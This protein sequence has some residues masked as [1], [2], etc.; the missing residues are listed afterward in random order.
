MDKLKKYTQKFKTCLNDLFNSVEQDISS[1]TTRKDPTTRGP[2]HRSPPKTRKASPKISSKTKTK[3][4]PE[5]LQ[6]FSDTDIK[7][8]S[9]YLYN[10]LDRSRKNVNKN[11]IQKL[12]KKLKDQA[13]FSK[14]IIAKPSEQKIED[15]TNVY[16]YHYLVY[17]SNASNKDNADAGNRTKSANR[18]KSGSGEFSNAGSGNRANSGEFSNAGSGN[19]ANSGSGN[20]ANSGE[21]SNPGSGNIANSGEFSNAGSGNMSKSG[22]GKFSDAGNA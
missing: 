10:E 1:P 15:L 2:L 5:F 21:F 13:G 16:I 12:L 6:D 18:A 20:R 14:Y 7:R 22:S 4:K 8:A 9:E 3:N 17:N 19:R 11:N